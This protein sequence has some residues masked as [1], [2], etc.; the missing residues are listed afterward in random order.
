MA[1]SSLQPH[2]HTLCTLL[3]SVPQGHGVGGGQGH[4]AGRQGGGE[5][6][7]TCAVSDGMDVCDCVAATYQVGSLG[8]VG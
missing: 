2:P 8:L 4:R 5:G 7:R 6:E 3:A 1:C